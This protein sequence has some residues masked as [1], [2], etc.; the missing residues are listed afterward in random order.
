MDFSFTPEQERIRQWVQTFA[1]TR[2]APLAAE[3]DERDEL[4][5]HLLA[6]MGELGLLGLPIP[7]AWGGVGADFL[8]YILA[9]EELSYACAA[10]GVVVAVHTAVG[11]F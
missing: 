5:R 9:V 4:P 1:Q 8:S 6:E 2:V 10:V 7:E 3:I 11:S